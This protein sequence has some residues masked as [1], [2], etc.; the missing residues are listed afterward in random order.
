MVFTVMSAV[1][2]LLESRIVL[3]ADLKLMID[4]L[5]EKRALDQVEEALRGLRLPLSS[6]NQPCALKDPDPALA[7]FTQSTTV[8]GKHHMTA[9]DDLLS[10]RRK[11]RACIAEQVRHMPVG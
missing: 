3:A 11:L 7:R 8:Q 1:C 6:Q 4:Q 10:A 2:L 5:P 9:I